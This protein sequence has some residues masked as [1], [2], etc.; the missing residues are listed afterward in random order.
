MQAALRKQ[1]I[2][3]LE[4]CIESLEYVNRNYPNATGW[5][6]RNDRVRAARTAIADIERQPDT[7]TANPTMPPSIRPV[8]PRRIRTVIGSMIT[9]GFITAI[10]DALAIIDGVADFGCVC[11]THM[12][13]GCPGEDCDGCPHCLGGKA[14]S[15]LSAH[16]GD[17]E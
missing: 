2:D 3:V 6:V 13:A 14:R 7:Y 15:F 9:G 11:P 10:E 5:G 16:E 4:G 12:A 17:D 8:P 1:L